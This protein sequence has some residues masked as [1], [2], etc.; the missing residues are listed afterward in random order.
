MRKHTFFL[1]CIVISLFL[2]PFRELAAE[3]L[4]RKVIPGYVR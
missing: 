1:L 4:I 3:I 2:V